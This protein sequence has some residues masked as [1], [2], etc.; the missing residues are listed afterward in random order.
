MLGQNLSKLSVI[1]NSFSKANKVFF[2]NFSGYLITNETIY[3]L[4]CLFEL[5]FATQ[6]SAN[7]CNTRVSQYDCLG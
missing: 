6:T 1:K 7:I 5:S 4:L 3:A 2:P